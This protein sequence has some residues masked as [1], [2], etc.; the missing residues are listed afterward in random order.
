MRIF[1]D[2]E[3]YEYELKNIA[4]L[5]DRQAFLFDT[6]LST[7]P[8]DRSSN[9]DHIVIR[10]DGTN[11]NSFGK[12]GGKESF[13]QEKALLYEKNLKNAYKRC[14]YHILSDFYKKDLD[15]GILTGIR[16]TKMYHEVYKKFSDKEAAIKHFMECSLASDKKTGIL[17][18]V[19]QVEQK[20]LREIDPN[21]YSI[22]VSLPFCPTKCNYCT[23]FSNE[24]TKKAHLIEPYLKTLS[25]ELRSV[26]QNEWVKKRNITS[27]YI[28][29][30]TPSSLDHTDLKSFLQ[31]LSDSI[32][33]SK[34]RE[35][36]FEA[37]R[38]DT[39]DPEKLKLIHGFGID[40]ISINPQTMIDDTLKKIGR[41]HSSEE[42]IKAFYDAR[43]A[44]FQNINMDI[45]IGLENE[46]LSD[47]EYTLNAILEMDPDSITVHSLAL[48]KASDL[49]KTISED[50][51]IDR[52][53]IVSDMME[54]VYERLE[55]DYFPYYLYRQKNIL[56]GQENVGFSKT[57]KESLYNIMIIEEYQNILSFG[58]GGVSRFVYPSENRIERISNTKNLEEYI[59]NIDLYIGKKREEMSYANNP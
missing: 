9:E 14:L 40:R 28:G 48:K 8:P 26:L 2:E 41:M 27:L 38:P 46:Q 3:K 4:V 21:D 47:L 35:I 49:S 45:I 34:V 22:Y 44:G 55:K 16:P 11:V 50:Q 39:I 19:N 24:I 17:H 10:S 18:Q 31:I 54:Y 1:I 29:G 13:H 36:T 20:I 53:R 23:F 32:D 59:R 51:R 25:L 56:G 52:S 15:W 30:G 12:I 33:F 42:I 37:G 5:F 6:D 7:A 58:P 57:G 43:E